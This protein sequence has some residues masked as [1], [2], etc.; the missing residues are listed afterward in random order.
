[1]KRSLLKISFALLI[2]STVM[3]SC[4]KDITTVSSTSEVSFALSGDNPVS[5][6]S[7]TPNSGGIVLAST[8]TTAAAGSIKWTSGI[9]N[10]TQ[11]K[12]EAKKNGKQV[13]IIS[14]NLSNVDL[15]ALTPTAIATKIDTGTY[16]EI[17]VRVILTKS[18]T[19]DIPI[20]LKGTFTS[21]GGAT[22]PVEFDFND[23]AIFKAEATNVTVTANTSVIAKLNLH[24][25][26]VLSNVA[27]AEL[28]KATRTN[29]TIV[30][31]SSSNQALYLK[32]L[33][34][35]VK[36]VESKGFEIRKK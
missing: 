5:P 26:L 24:M 36:A 8:A 11:F 16:K 15:F 20:T 7:A 34:T 3:V 31:S 32:A 35:I 4:K 10:I 14:K 33:I 28:D 29:G 17:E 22:V 2:A 23:D 18:A 27:A 9:A 1:M 19:A 6:I 21:A 25:N 13:E 12:L 30:I